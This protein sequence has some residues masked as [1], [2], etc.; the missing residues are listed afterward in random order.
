M[1][2]ARRERRRAADRRELL[3]VAERIFS[4]RGYAGASIRDI[5]AEAGFSV[6][7]LYQIFPGKDEL[8]VAVLDAV[9][10]EYLAVTRAALM[11]PSFGERLAALTRASGTFVGGRRSFLEIVVAERAAIHGVLDGVVAEKLVHHRKVRRQ[12]VVELMK[13]GLAEGVLRF[14]DAEFLASAYLGLVTQCQADALAGG[15]G[16][17]SPDDVVSLFCRGTATAARTPRRTSR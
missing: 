11:L 15:R 16:L 3:Q 5:A 2:A 9:W 14:P 4:A 13:S 6:G 10:Q 12:Q 8:F 1:Q 17:P 7:A